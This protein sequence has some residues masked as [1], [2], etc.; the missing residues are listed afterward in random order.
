MTTVQVV[1][2]ERMIIA[3]TPVEKGINASFA[4]GYSGIVPF[5]DI[6]EIGDL[7]K[8]NAVELPN[9]YE[10]ILTNTQD[11]RVELPWDFVRHYCDRTYRPRMEMVAAKGGQVLGSRVRRLRET[12][13]LTQE[14][15]AQ[16]AGIGRI[17]QVRLENGKHVPKLSTLKAIAHVLE[18]PIEDLL[19]GPDDSGTMD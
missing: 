6:P 9:P 8:L 14:A 5:T 19:A 7:S 12:A 1:N 17:T 10:I 13:G 15:L 11:E 3:V 16:A 2:A 18:K 4:D